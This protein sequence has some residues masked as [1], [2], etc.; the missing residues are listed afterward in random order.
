MRILCHSG[1]C[2]HA[3]IRICECQRRVSLRTAAFTVYVTTDSHRVTGCEHTLCCEP[4]VSSCTLLP[5]V[6]NGISIIILNLPAAHYRCMAALVNCVHLVVPHAWLPCMSPPFE[7]ST[8]A[9]IACTSQARTQPCVC[10]R[11][12]WIV[13]VPHQSPASS[14]T[15]PSH[16]CCVISRV[17][18]IGPKDGLFLCIIGSRHPLCT[19]DYKGLA[20]HG[21]QTMSISKVSMR[22]DC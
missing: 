10:P 22:T 19:K 11:S 8:L 18:V 4:N 12:F 17:R 1:P 14:S 20:L 13:S 6:V 2:A 5:Q 7:C 3:A 21:P 16:P 9:E 15:A